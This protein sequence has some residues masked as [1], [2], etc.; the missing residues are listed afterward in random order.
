MRASSITQTCTFHSVTK[1]AI[2]TKQPGCFLLRVLN[3]G[4]CSIS[5]YSIFKI[6]GMSKLVSW[7]RRRGVRLQ[8]AH[9]NQVLALGVDGGKP[10]RADMCWCI[11]F[12]RAGL[13]KA[14]LLLFI[15]GVRLL[16][17]ALSLPQFVELPGLLD[18]GSTVVLALLPQRGWHPEVTRTVWEGGH[19]QRRQSLAAV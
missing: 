10:D 17:V 5:S 11:L 15:T 16:G 13:A 19:L 4:I 2:F 1:V 3:T 9:F 7:G 12:Q 14:A 6:L 8:A 18:Q